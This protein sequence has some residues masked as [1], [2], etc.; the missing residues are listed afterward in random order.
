MRPFRHPFI[1]THFKCQ[2]LSILQI[3]T[4]VQK[5]QKADN[6]TSNPC[7]S[8]C[9]GPFLRGSRVRCSAGFVVVVVWLTMFLD[10]RF[11]LLCLGLLI[12]GITG[13]LAEDFFLYTPLL[14]H[15]PQRV[16]FFKELY[17]A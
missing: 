2:T 5:F 1:L 9:P 6:Y 10:N 16:N 17:G 15:P 11:M 3:S 8:L 13:W 4:C 12:S 7:P 14:L